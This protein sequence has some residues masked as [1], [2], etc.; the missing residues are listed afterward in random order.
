MRRFIPGLLCALVLFSLPVSAGDADRPYGHVI[1]PFRQVFIKLFT[2]QCQM[3]SLDQ[4]KSTAAQ[5]STQEKSTM[6]YF[7]GPD[8]HEQVKK[9]LTPEKQNFLDAEFSMRAEAKPGDMQAL[10]PHI[11][12]LSDNNL[13]LEQHLASL[14]RLTPEEMASQS[15]FM[16]DSGRK[17]FFGILTR[18]R[19]AAV[20]DSTPDWVLLET[21]RRKLAKVKSYTCIAY[22][23]ELINGKLQGVEKILFKS[24][25]QPWSLYM[26]WLD[27]PFKGRELVYN[28]A[29][30]GAGTVRVRES[31]VLGVVPVT[32]PVSSDIARRGTNHYITDL[33]LKFLFNTIEKDYRK[34]APK[35]DQKRINHGIVDLDGVKVYKMESIL[36]RNPALGYY[37]YRI[38][39]YI[40]FMN[41]LEV[42]AEMFN[43]DDIMWESYHYTQIKINP[44]LTDRDFD[45]K[46]PEY[47]L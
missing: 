38:V 4:L 46:N 24:R 42:K 45:P 41:S 31:G 17:T 30:L 26:K 8:G 19:A 37:C 3:M 18:D 15:F 20:L 32:L 33:G 14:K 27:G 11:L 23:Q 16:G 25:D 12:G 10:Y 35:N 43:W 13:T 21:G 28:E 5:L 2:I 6:S 22:K 39:H 34:A 1:P 9:A 47:D 7:L 40:D 44:G 36:P 29:V